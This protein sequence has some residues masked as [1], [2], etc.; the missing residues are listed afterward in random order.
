MSNKEY[1]ENLFERLENE[2]LRPGLEL[3]EGVSYKSD[4]TIAYEARIESQQLD[5]PEFIPLLTDRLSK[6]KVTKEKINIIHVLVS[7]ADKV[8]DH[9]IADFIINFV[10]NEKVRWV[11]DV[12]LGDLV[13]SNI[14][15]DKEKEYL[16]ELVKN[17]DWQIK[18]SSLGLLKKLDDSYSP[19]IENICIELIE[20]NK[21]KPHELNSICGVLSKHGSNKSL[22]RIKEVART[23]SKAFTVNTAI[24]AIASI[25]GTNELEFFREISETNRNNDVKSMSTQALCKYG[26]ETVIDILIKRAKNILS[27]TRK[28][29]IHYVGGSQPELVHI[30]KFLTQYTDSRV[31]KLID[32]IISKKLDL[33]DET[34]S[35]W[36]HEN[37]KKA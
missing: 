15:V 5:N 36:F 34:E 30:L 2:N 20:L 27:K 18:L 9:S 26:D 29:K 17:K 23:N 28:S 24:G 4:L 22:E 35:K 14:Q 6:E 19:R 1:L 21:K 8:Q 37:I 32:F 10:K 7:L 25:N 31:D 33:M 11:K 3:P 16:F 13:R 12:A